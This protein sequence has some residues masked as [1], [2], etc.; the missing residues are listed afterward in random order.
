MSVENAVQDSITINFVADGLSALGKIW[1]RGQELTVTKGTDDYES[2]LDRDGNSWLDLTEAE[3]LAYWGERKFAAGPWQGAGFDLDADMDVRFKDGSQKLTE[4]EK[5]K[6]LEATK[7]TVPP[8]E[9]AAAPELD[10]DAIL[11]GKSDTS[12]KK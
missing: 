4:A 12:G 7:T 11:S 8:A 6:L 5:A 1:Y 10:F 3:Q 9:P 2:T